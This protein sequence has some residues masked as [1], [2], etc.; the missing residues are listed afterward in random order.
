MATSIGDLLDM[1]NARAAD[2]SRA[3]RG[4]ALARLGRTLSALRVD[5][6]TEA[7]GSLHEDHVSMLAVACQ[8]L[9]PAARAADSRLAELSGAAGDAVTTLRESLTRQSRWALAVAYADT[10][11]TLAKVDQFNPPTHPADQESLRL[12]HSAAQQIARDAAL[13]PPTGSGSVILDAPIPGQAVAEPIWAEGV[14][15]AVA[16]LVRATRPES[17]P[18]TIGQTLAVTLAA[19]QLA[20]RAAEL[21]GST[22]P[23]AGARALDAAKAWRAVRVELR[24]FNDG[25]RRPQDYMPPVVQVAERVHAMTTI[26]F[27]ASGLPGRQQA[28]IAAAAQHLPTLAINLSRT[29]QQWADGGMLLASD[30]D[31]PPREDRADMH[32]HRYRQGGIVRMTH[33]VRADGADLAETIAALTDVHT[34]AVVAAA[35]V[36]RATARG[37]VTPPRRLVAVHQAKLA[38]HAHGNTVLAAQ[39]DTY[40][41]LRAVASE[42]P[43]PSRGR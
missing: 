26:G 4:A 18:L 42:P 24:P 2:A 25:T 41:R 14:L 7:V 43:S 32:L 8:A 27:H 13:D 6:L 23:V 30:R 33:L 19:E 15:N 1:V 35:D 3:E 37:P 9:R 21:V 40:R 22:T 10:A 29:V 36:S 11:L 31:L 5:G 39:H 34:L 20:V 38:D 28:E 17:E 16:D 12:I